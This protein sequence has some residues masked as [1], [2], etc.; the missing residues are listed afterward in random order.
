MIL[1]APAAGSLQATISGWD[2]NLEL[3][4]FPSPLWR[5]VI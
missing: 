1:S 4:Q 5:E 3:E 2:F